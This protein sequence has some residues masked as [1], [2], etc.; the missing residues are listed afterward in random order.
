MST[1]VLELEQIQDSRRRQSHSRRKGSLIAALFN[2]HPDH[3]KSD[4]REARR[5]QSR[6]PSATDSR[7][8]R[9]VPG[10]FNSVAM[11]QARRRMDGAASGGV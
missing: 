1:N 11:A 4:E 5:L 10:L 6:K 9:N 2:G 3:K 7:F 8:K